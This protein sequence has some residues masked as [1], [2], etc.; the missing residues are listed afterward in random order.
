[1]GKLAKTLTLGAIFGFIAGLLFA[2]K[3]GEESRKTVGE[4][5]EKGKEKINEIKG[6][7]KKEE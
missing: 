3:K 4:V 2:P 5:I 7:F 1:M 6:S